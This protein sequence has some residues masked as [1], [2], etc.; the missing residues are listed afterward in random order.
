MR[1]VT[2]CSVLQS[3]TKESI[4]REYE[5]SPPLHHLAFST[6]KRPVAGRGSI[7]EISME[8]LSK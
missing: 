8:H 6:V 1:C 5:M 4:L 7:G 2:G 3:F